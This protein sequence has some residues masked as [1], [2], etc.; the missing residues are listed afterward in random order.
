MRPNPIWCPYYFLERQCDR[1]LFGAPISEATMR[2]NPIWRPYVWSD[3]AT[4]PY[5]AP[6]LFS[7]AT[8]RKA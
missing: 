7:G 6:L 3:I 5:L 4:E 2:P 1:T 8:M